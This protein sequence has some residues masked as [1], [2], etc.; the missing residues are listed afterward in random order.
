MLRTTLAGLRAH[1]L[2]LLLTSLAIA[3]GVGF[4]AGTF[5]LTDTLE[6]GFT[7]KVTASADKVTVAVLPPKSQDP[8]REAGLTARDLDKLRAVPGVDEAQGLLRGEVILLGKNG[9]AAGDYPAQA[10]SVTAGKLNRT[11]LVGGGY[12]NGD[13]QAVLD[14]NTARAQGFKVGDTITVLDRKQARHEFE[15]VGIFD[16]GIDRDLSFYGGVGFTLPTAQALSGVKTF[17]EID[18]AGT[19]PAE[20]L[21]RAVVAE[22]FTAQTSAE[23]A[24]DLAKKSGMGTEELGMALLLFGVIAMFV[25]ALVIYNTFTILIAQRTR[26]MALLRCMGATRGQ[27][28]GSVLLESVVV[29]LLSSVLGL[30]AGYG[31]GALAMAIL[32]AV[33]APLPTGAAATLAP[34]TIGISLAIGLVVTVVAALLP[35][36]AAT[37]VP[38][39]AALRTQAE[40]QT[41]R[42]GVLRAILAGV[43]LLGGGG[44]VAFT[45][46][47]KRGDQAT[48][49]TA[50]A[51][52]ALL[53]L[54]VLVLGPTL[55]KPLSSLVGWV[56]R[57]LFGVPGRLAVNNSARNPRRAATTTIALTVGVT[58]MTLISVITASS[59]ASIGAELDQQFPADYV[60]SSQSAEQPI[61]RA[62][63]DALSGR[64]EFEAVVRVREVDSRLGGQRI[65]AGSFDGPLDPPLASGSLGAL[66]GDTALVPGYL[67]ESHGLKVGSTVEVKAAKGRTVPLKVVGVLKDE[68]P[69]SGVT[70]PPDAFDRHFGK[71]G[72]Q[73]VYVKNRAATNRDEARMVVDAAVEAYPVVKVLSTTE[74]RGEF[75]DALDMALMIITGLLGLAVLISLVGIANT[76]SLSVHERTRESALLRALGLTRPQLRNMLSI[77][78]LVLG[79]V[80]ALVGVLLGVGF[81]WLAIR[82]LL[83]DTVFVLPYAQV[84]VLVLGAGLAGVIASLL[85]ARRAARTSV[86]GALASG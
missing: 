79:L 31:L 62:V 81:G 61:P 55:V 69:L 67:A 37:R 73:Q 65:F 77:E 3:L 42:A 41:F 17:Y 8:E 48:L 85:P 15:L 70:L 35:A 60:L 71:V 4:I 2:R 29:G 32:Q 59:R 20:Q 83:E 36:R 56:P 34:A 64:A 46:T 54:A 86:V 18:L 14:E 80:G 33:D 27:V 78:A 50:M 23:L 22:G 25:A 49:F 51:G 76:L 19:V 5:V 68:A 84:G 66:K 11:T 45:L 52:C 47:M 12:P 63:G 13:S 75:E 53:F 38:P 30:A 9:R 28:F 43:L 26:E 72:D 21:K 6:A 57:K 74:M 44:L 82:S 1:K 7:Q 24:S 40:E 39:I 10:I 16:P 58:L